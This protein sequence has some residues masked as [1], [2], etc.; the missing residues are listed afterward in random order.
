MRASKTFAIAPALL[1]LSL[2]CEAYESDVHYGLTYWLSAQ[3][4]FDAQQ[5]QEIAR[6]DELT[7]TG[8][9]D[10]KHSIVLHLC[11]LRDVKASEQTRALH[12]RAQHPA[13]ALPSERPVDEGAPYARTQVDSKIADGHH[14]L[15]EQQSGFG[16]ALHGYQD[17]FSHKG[18]SNRFRPCPTNWIWSHPVDKG[19]VFSHVADQTFKDIPKCVTA[20][21]KVYEFMLK[22]RASL[23]LDSTPKAWDDLR[24]PVESFCKTSTKVDKAQWYQEH[25][26]PQANAIAKNTSLDD[27]GRSFYREDRIDLRPGPVVA[28]IAQSTAKVPEYERQEPN[29]VPTGDPDANFKSETMYPHIK[30]DEKAQERAESFLKAWLTA[31]PDKLEAALAPYFEKKTLSEDE[32]EF[33]LL[34]RLRLKDQGQQSVEKLSLKSQDVN[35]EDYILLN[36]ENW[37]SA[38]IPPRGLKSPVLVS[39]VDGEFVVIAILRNAPNE[40]VLIKQTKDLEFKQPDSFIFH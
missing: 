22:Y 3:A 11:L 26:V 20:A 38:L 7:D 34:R 9:L 37:Q 14:E 17:S 27:G 1:I 30:Y 25:G 32:H 12:F 10:A 18:V 6:Q 36:E 39:E 33:S 13:P 2:Y 23:S 24:D 31:P 21:E 19:N 15:P 29:W 40:V 16:Q 35:P 8:M 5:T 28:R 4:G